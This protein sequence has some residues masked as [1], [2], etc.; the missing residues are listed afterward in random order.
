MTYSYGDPHNPQ[1]DDERYPTQDAAEHA[2]DNAAF[3]RA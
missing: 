3:L 1:P 2:A